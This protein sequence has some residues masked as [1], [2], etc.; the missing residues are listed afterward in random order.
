MDGLLLGRARTVSADRSM[1]AAPVA[2]GWLA[3]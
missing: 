2:D 1:T 3:R